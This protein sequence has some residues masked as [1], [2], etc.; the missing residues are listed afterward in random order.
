MF[1]KSAQL[2]SVLLAA[3]ASAYPF[4]GTAVVPANNKQVI[5]T[6]T[7]STAGNELLHKAFVNQT[8]T[9]KYTP[10][11]PPAGRPP[12][13][14]AKRDETVSEDVI[15][16]RNETASDVGVSK[17]N[18]FTDELESIK[19]KIFKRNETADALEAVEKE[20]VARNE[21][22]GVKRGIN[23]LPPPP[24]P[25]PF[26]SH[27]PHTKREESVA[28][29]KEALSTGTPDVVRREQKGTGV[30]PPKYT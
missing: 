25:P 1:P 11:P 29:L 13:Q 21:T 30:A 4:P 7:A 28:G 14:P 10:P 2:V 19:D 16:K 12:Y 22:E 26:H 8:A 24:P 15:V 9:D 5:P 23:R 18:E 6:G 27:R 17:R 3:S 20:I